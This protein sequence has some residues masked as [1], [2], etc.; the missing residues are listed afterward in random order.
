MLGGE[1]LVP[2]MLSTVV[3]SPKKFWSVLTCMEYLTAPR[4]GVQSST[5]STIFVAAL[6]AGLTSSAAS[7]G[8]VWKVRISDQPVSTPVPKVALTRQWY[9]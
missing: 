4:T 1:Y 8:P 6:S 7:S 5:T 3:T 9:G 2:V